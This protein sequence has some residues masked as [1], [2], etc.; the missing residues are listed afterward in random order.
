MSGNKSQELVTP[1]KF[2]SIIRYHCI[3]VTKAAMKDTN[4]GKKHWEL[5]KD[6]KHEFEKTYLKHHVQ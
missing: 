1:M 5:T 2:K 6:T 3:P 4:Y